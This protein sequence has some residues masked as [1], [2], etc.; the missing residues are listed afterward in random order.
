MSLS[1]RN[2]LQLGALGAAATAL[3]ARAQESW[4]NVMLVVVGGMGWPQERLAPVLPHREAL[5]A[6]STVYTRLYTADPSPGPALT[7][8]LTGR[9]SAEHGVVLDGLPL[10]PDAP[11]LLGQARQG[12][13][14]VAW[15]GGFPVSGRRA[16]DAARLLAGPGD[17][18]RTV[19][20]VRAFLAQQTTTRPWLLGVRLDPLA[21]LR[22]HRR[23]LGPQPRLELG[24]APEELP[25]PPKVLTPPDV[26]PEG[27]LAARG[28]RVE[29]PEALRTDAWALARAT[30]VGD[31][32]LGSLVDALAH[33]AHDQRT[34]LVVVGDHGDAAGTWG[35]R[36][37]AAPLES[38]LRAPLFFR[39]GT[40]RTARRC[41]APLS[42]V[43]LAGT[44]CRVMGVPVVPGASDFDL[45][46]PVVREGAEVPGA[47][48]CD[49]MVSGDVVVGEQGLLLSW[50]EGEGLRQVVRPEGGS[51]Q[52]PAG[53]P[54]ALALRQLRSARM[55]DL[56]PAALHRGGLERALAARS[57]FGE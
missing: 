30:E 21:A 36:G 10:A 26:V 44:L 28:A 18:R 7:S 54:A 57:S 22:R 46:T 50:R 52:D 31:A 13:R 27:F 8:L 6:E 11:T 38:V 39:W 5:A 42:A 49:L 23:R 48:H 43:H 41:G 24:L 37:G 4:T 32:L 2:L 9:P 17:D 47:V 19:A 40:D 16:G 29:D 55:A 53:H 1:R 45:R 56:R 33:S 35:L 25:L 51:W 15:A 14:T 34:L 12:G 3:P 20:A